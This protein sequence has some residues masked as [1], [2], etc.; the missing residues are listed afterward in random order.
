MEAKALHP[1]PQV[2]HWPGVHFRGSFVTSRAPSYREAKPMGVCTGLCS[3]PSTHCSL[4]RGSLRPSYLLCL[5]RKES[6]VATGV[7]MDAWPGTGG[8]CLCVQWE[9]GRAEGPGLHIAQI[10]GW[11]GCLESNDPGCG[12]WIPGRWGGGGGREQPCLPRPLCCEALWLTHS[13][14]AIPLHASREG[15]SHFSLS[16]V[17]I[18]APCS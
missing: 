15:K 2:P 1:L 18:L 7:R 16:S 10:P 14:F 13:L 9:L 8:G 5:Q 11:G 3:A 17:S 4:G 6:W 12:P